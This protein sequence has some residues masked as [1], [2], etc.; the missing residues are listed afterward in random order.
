VD[1]YLGGPLAE[2]LESLK[3]FAAPDDAGVTV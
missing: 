1:D 3:P 2:L